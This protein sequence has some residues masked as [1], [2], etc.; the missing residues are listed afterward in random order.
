MHFNLIN[1]KKKIILLILIA[2]IISGCQAD[3][4]NKENGKVENRGRPY[5]V[6]PSSSPE[7]SRGPTSAP[8]ERKAEGLTQAQAITTNENIRL[9]LPRKT[10]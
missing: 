4:E 9:T 3:L 1:M 8:P 6:G 2:G 5:S 10:E 7:S